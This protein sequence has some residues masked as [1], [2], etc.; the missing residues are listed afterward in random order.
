MRG[1]ARTRHE[2]FNRLARQF[3]ARPAKQGFSLPVHLDNDAV[4]IGHHDRVRRKLEE[5]RETLLCSRYLPLRTLHGRNILVRHHHVHRAIVRK[6]GNAAVVPPLFG[7]RMARVLVRGQVLRP[8]HDFLNGVQ[9]CGRVTVPVKRGALAYG[10]VIHPFAHRPPLDAV[11]LRSLRE[12]APAPVRGNDSAL[13][14]EHRDLRAE[15]VERGANQAVFC[16]FLRHFLWRSTT[17]AVRV[18]V[19]RAVR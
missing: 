12:F 19:P 17:R 7:C 15:C 9:D 4:S 10:E 1:T 5:V 14:V 18:R 11:G 2:H 3:G 8:A 16:K 13:A 6:A